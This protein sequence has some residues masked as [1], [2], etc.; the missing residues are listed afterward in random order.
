MENIKELKL[1]AI[2]YQCATN[3]DYCPEPSEVDTIKETYLFADDYTTED[4]KEALTKHKGT[5]PE[6]LVNQMIPKI[7]KLGLG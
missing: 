7:D 5:S 1:L 4:I 6:R 3:Y 2:A